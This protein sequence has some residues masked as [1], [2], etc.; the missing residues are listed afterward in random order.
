MLRNYSHVLKINLKPVT[1]IMNLFNSR[2]PSCKCTIQFWASHYFRCTTA[3]TASAASAAFQSTSFRN[4]V[5]KEE[6]TTSKGTRKS[7]KAGARSFWS[8]QKKVLSYKQYFGDIEPTWLPEIIWRKKWKIYQVCFW[9]SY[10]TTNFP[11]VQIRI[12]TKVKYSYGV[13]RVPALRGFW[14][15][16]KTVLREIHVSGTRL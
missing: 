16:K 13:Q 14:D 1:F 10:K 9:D 6:G 4:C 3:S 12:F 2:R 5:K 7:W 8:W 11:K 15:L